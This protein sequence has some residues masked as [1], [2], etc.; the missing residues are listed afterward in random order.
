[1]NKEYWMESMST[2]L[3][4]AGVTVTREQLEKISDGAKDVA[5]MESEATDAIY[6]PNPLEA[7]VSNLE[8]R[9]K[10]A[11]SETDKQRQDF[12][13]NI[14]MRHNCEPHQVE[15]EGDGDATIYK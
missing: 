3:E 14:C 1:M 7:E 5:Y 9:L 2:V 10:R 8:Q 6:I 11:E 15:L 12:V 4:D 13:K